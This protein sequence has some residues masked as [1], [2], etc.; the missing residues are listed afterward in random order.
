MLVCGVPLDP[1]Q[2]SGPSEVDS[3]DRNKETVVSRWTDPPE[4]VRDFRLP[5]VSDGTLYRESKRIKTN[6]L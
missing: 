6:C 4:G 1:R 2:F 5:F 3:M